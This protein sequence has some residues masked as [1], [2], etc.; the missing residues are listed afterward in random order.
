MITAH[1]NV[2]H[3]S[4]INTMIV[5]TYDCTIHGG[6]YEYTINVRLLSSTTRENYNDNIRTSK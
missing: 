4:I 3:S 5:T 2:D 6:S 1:E